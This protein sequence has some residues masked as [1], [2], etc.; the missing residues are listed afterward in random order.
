MLTNFQT[1]RQGLLGDG[2]D[3]HPGQRGRPVHRA[4][5]QG[6]ATRR[7]RPSR[8]CRRCS[9]PTSPTPELIRQKVAEAIDTAEG[10]APKKA[11]EAT[12][13]TEEARQGPEDPGTGVTGGS[14]GSLS[15]GYAANE[16]EDLDTAC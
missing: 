1:D 6:Q 11:A 7:S 3:E 16:S 8:S 13:G 12:T 4:G 2:L 14:V 9:T 5:A 15:D 10:T